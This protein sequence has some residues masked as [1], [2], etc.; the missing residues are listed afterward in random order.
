MEIKRVHVGGWFQRTRL[1]LGEVYDFLRGDESPLDLD[2][3][4]LTQL[5]DALQIAHLEM[6]VDVLEYVKVVT[7]HGITVRMY[8]DGLIVLATEH[9]HDLH[10][11][12]QSLT[13]YYEEKLSPAFSYIFS[14]GAP[15]PKELANIKT[16]YPYFVSVSNAGRDEVLSLFEE[17]EQELYFEVQKEDFSIYRGDKLYIINQSGVTDDQVQRFIEEQVFLREFRGQ[18]HRYLNMHRIIWEKIADVIERGEMKGHEIGGFK[19]KVDRYKKTI[20]FIGTRI[21]Q[22]GTYLHTRESIANKDKRLVAFEEVLGY[23][24]ETLDDTLS[25]IKDIWDL[26]RKY[27]DSAV[28]IFSDLQ[29]DSTSSSISNLTIVTS[30]GVG[31]ALIGLFETDSAPEFTAFGFIYF[32]ILAA[33]GYS[34]NKLM[35]WW[36]RQRTYG[37]SDIELDKNIK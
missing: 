28:K 11:D 34:V 9:S 37:V 17:F 32:F 7:E 1:H 18:M 2:A 24:H 29:S 20:D 4:K 31:A 36:Y 10:K 6:T 35:K 8:E 3:R 30:M 19:N 27:V 12:I 33:V 26:T 23:K 5:R 14:L 13:G 15:V 25:Y 21:N 16:V 22:M